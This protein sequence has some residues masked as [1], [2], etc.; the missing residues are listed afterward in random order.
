MPKCI[1]IEMVLPSRVRL[2]ADHIIN[3]MIIFLCW[4]G[5]TF[6]IIRSSLGRV[7][8]SFLYGVEYFLLDS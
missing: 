4:G 6:P 8:V 2:Q 7:A 5:I 1:V 3:K